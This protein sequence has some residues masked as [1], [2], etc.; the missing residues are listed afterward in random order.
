MLYCP[1]C[2]AYQKDPGASTCH[3]CGFDVSVEEE[4][5]K[6]RALEVE[7]DEIKRFTHNNRS[8]DHTSPCKVC[9]AP[10]LEQ[11]EEVQHEVE[12][13]KIKVG[14]L[15]LMGSEISKRSITLMAINV[16]GRSCQEGHRTYTSYTCRDKPLCP[17]CLDLLMVYG[18]VILSCPRCNRHYSMAD[19]RSINPEE[20][21]EAEGW[22]RG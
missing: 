19:F 1:N 3:K 22:N 14:G 12:G 9:G 7:E 5:R 21:L 20:A 10:T 4:R 11:N 13:A 16:K 8:Y 2:S 17:M 6:R 18:S 15:K